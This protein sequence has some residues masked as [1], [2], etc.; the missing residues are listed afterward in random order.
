MKLKNITLKPNQ[1]KDNPTHK[2][3]F[4]LHIFVGLACLILISSFFNIG[5]TLKEAQAATVPST[6]GSVLTTP[7]TVSQIFGTDCVNGSF[8]VAVGDTNNFGI[9]YTSSDG[10]SNWAVQ[11]TP[12]AIT[13]LDDVSCPTVSFCVAVGGANNAGAIIYSTD[14]GMTWTQATLPSGSTSISAV[15]CSSTSFCVSVGSGASGAVILTSTNSGVS[16]SYQTVPSAAQILYDISCTSSSFCVVDGD[17]N[18]GAIVLVSSNSGVTWNQPA[19]PSN[20]SDLYGISCTSV[21]FCVGVGDYSNI[22]TGSQNGVVIVSNDTGAT[23]N[24]EPIPSDVAYLNAVACTGGSICIAVG[25]NANYTTSIT[26]TNGG[27]GWNEL[28]TPTVLSDLYTVTCSSESLCIAAGDL[29]L[30]TGAIIST[31]NLGTNWNMTNLPIGTSAFYSI[32]CS[33]TSFCVGVGSSNNS[34]AS[35][36]YTN[37]AGNSWTA[38]NLPA[39][40]STLFGV[41]CLSTSFCIAV[42][43]ENTSS[44][45]IG[46]ALVSTDGGANWS[47]GSVPSTVDTLASVTCTSSTFCIAVGSNFSAATGTSTGSI[48]IS[49]NQGASWTEANIPSGTSGLEGVSCQSSTFCIAGGELTNNNTGLNT[50]E[51]LY[52]LN[53]GTSWTLGS[54]PSTASYFNSISC[55][56][57]TNCIG[58]GAFYNSSTSSATGVIF[59]SSNGGQSWTQETISS[60]S[61]DFYGVTCVTTT[62]YAVG[63]TSSNGSVVLSSLNNGLSWSAD[64]IPTSVG[65][66]YTVTCTTQTYCMAA[67]Q[68]NVP[69]IGGDIIQLS[70]PTITSISPS[71]GPVAGGTVVDIA[72]IGL[73]NVT[74]LTF[75]TTPASSIDAIS[76]TEIQAIAPPEGSGIVN[77]TVTTANGTSNTVPYTYVT[78]I[79]Y[80]PITPLRICDTRPVGAGI[81][82]NQCNNGTAS[83]GTMSA[84]S[85]ININVTGTFGTVN[86]PSSATAVV[87]NVTATNT[88]QNGGF[89]TIFPTP[90]SGSTVPNISDINWNMGNTVANLVVVKIGSNDSINIYNAIGSTDV[91]VDVMGYYG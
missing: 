25:D 3:N 45:S 84:G 19:I 48:L 14:G 32:S 82:S 60:G 73:N 54:A 74:S 35:A 11:N 4:R 30:G 70:A 34:S 83:N 63:Q 76:P 71:T 55:S 28:P 58:V 27:L 66:V 17:T 46:V 47:M 22:S 52:T 79:I 9:V 42:G 91:I 33:S 75:G 90:A 77:V 65:S 57:T 80:T 2:L 38:S 59:N 20:I 41:S 72:G 6:W 7:P 43:Y 16:W 87:L 86:I 51:D 36:F 62:C 44:S 21:S 12:E 37:N 18:S 15:S 26:S 8:C 1:S 5:F 64:T 85:T 23:W 49:T 68:G 29:N 40:L 10:G 13:Y 61:V 31:A 56:S 50:S 24:L 39:G 53:G 67:A 78:N 81:A 88:T 89:L 69:N